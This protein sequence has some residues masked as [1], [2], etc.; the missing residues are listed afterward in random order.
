MQHLFTGKFGTQVSLLH[1]ITS[2]WGSLFSQEQFSA[3]SRE[4]ELRQ[5]WTNI[6]QGACVWDL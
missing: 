6:S 1:I 5:T 3:S 4:K 2:E